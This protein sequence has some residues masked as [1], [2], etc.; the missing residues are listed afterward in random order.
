MEVGQEPEGCSGLRDHY[1]KTSDEVTFGRHG[2]SGPSLAM[3]PRD[4]TCGAQCVSK[5]E[6]AVSRPG[7]GV[8][9]RDNESD[10]SHGLPANG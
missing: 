3:F 2:K 9:S 6:P 5:R 8:R 10:E 7:T 4:L 1:I